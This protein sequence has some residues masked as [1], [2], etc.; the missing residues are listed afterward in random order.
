MWVL[1]WG[2]MAC[3]GSSDGDDS[4]DTPV[5]VTVVR[6]ED[7]REGAVTD[8][9]S[10]TSVVEAERAADIV[11]IAP[12]VVLSIH[13]DD[14]DPVKR[15][16]LLAVLESVSL[17]A[18]AER[19][20]AEVGRL[21]KQVEDMKKLASRGA[22]SARELEDLEYQLQAAK[23]NARE[24]QRSFGQ[25]RLTAPFDGVVARR[26]VKVGQLAN[27]T[28]FRIVDL[29][30]LKVVV[31]LPERDVGRVQVGQRVKLESAYDPEI[32]GEGTVTR[33]SPVIDA[34]TGTFRATVEV[35]DG[36]LRPG[37][38][39]NTRI[40][41]DRH[42]GVTVVPRE[43]L[44][45]ED[46]RPVVF[47]M[48]PAPP[49]EPEE[50]EEAPKPEPS[51]DPGFVASRKPLEIGLLDDDGVEVLSGVAS[52]DAVITVGQSNLKDGARVRAVEDGPTLVPEGGDAG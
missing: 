11:P 27:S 14:G 3:S 5:P 34:T 45:W 24:A 16:D 35:T 21:Q 47:V 50:G 26:D 51:G 20:R 38:F 28:A 10:T 15:G 49:P 39:V 18:G 8:V 44:M 32:R 52:G 46:G 12:G 41:V 2:L 40:E 48:V 31:D 9:L 22:V 17:S 30:T 7:V 29:G 6:T 25:T 33:L 43:A 19:S 4:E 1:I 23:T 13:A 42:D 36:S 37:Q